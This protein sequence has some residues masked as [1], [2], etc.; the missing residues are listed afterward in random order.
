MRFYIFTITYDELRASYGLDLLF[1]T[2]RQ[3]V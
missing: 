3:L 2:S 1:D